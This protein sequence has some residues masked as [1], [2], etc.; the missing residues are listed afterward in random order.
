[1]SP[2]TPRGISPSPPLTRTG[3]W[4]NG[5]IK[6]SANGQEPTHM[7]ANIRSIHE[8]SGNHDK[9]SQIRPDQGLYTVVLSGHVSQ[10]SKQGKPAASSEGASASQHTVIIATP[11][12]A[13]TDPFSL[14]FIGTGAALPR[15]GPARMRAGIWPM[16]LA[17]VR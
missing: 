3:G 2:K 9:S 17:D 13:S 11:N 12:L 5:W 1:M 8:I 16:W 4:M 7:A 14:F 15:S 10:A 6:P